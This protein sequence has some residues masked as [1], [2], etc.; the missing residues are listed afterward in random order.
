[1]LY[2]NR[3]RQML[4]LTQDLPTVYFT[5]SCNRLLNDIHICMTD[6]IKFQNKQ[7]KTNNAI[8]LQLLT[9]LGQKPNTVLFLLYFMIAKDKGQIS[10]STNFF[11][12]VCTR[13]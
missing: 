6:N 10:Q 11:R 1:M 13:T 7:P 4:I 9:K 5:T 2:M 12:G 3:K 8:V